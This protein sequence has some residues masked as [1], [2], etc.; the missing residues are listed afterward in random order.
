MFW[1]CWLAS[2]KG[3]WR[4]KYFYWSGYLPGAR[5]SWSAYG[6]ADATATSSS[7]APVK[8]RMVFLSGASLP[9]LSWK[10]RPLNGRSSGLVSWLCI[11]RIVVHI[12]EYCES[13]CIR[14]NSRCILQETEADHCEMLCVI[15]SDTCRVVN[16]Q[17]CHIL[18]DCILWHFVKAK[19][20]YASWFGA[21][22]GLTFGLSSSLLAAN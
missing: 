9:R 19:F 7:L 13:G 8:S 20:H 10:K 12:N 5:S 14:S 11:C 16:V 18:S 2:R 15:C 4:V 6:P 22:S 3:I 1:R 17:C 21:G